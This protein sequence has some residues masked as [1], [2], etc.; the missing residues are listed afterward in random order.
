MHCTL[1]EKKNRSLTPVSAKLI[2]A[3]DT[4]IKSFS[5]TLSV[6]F[7][8]QNNLNTNV[9][10]VYWNVITPYSNYLKGSCKRTKI[11]HDSKFHSAQNF[12]SPANYLV[13][14]LKEQN[15]SQF[16]ME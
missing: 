6:H 13:N 2:A 10:A 11:A 1:K 15:V 9:S 5:E 7:Q 12:F 3:K 14:W 16:R 4:R 8:I